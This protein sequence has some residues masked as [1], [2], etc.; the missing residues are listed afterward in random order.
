[1]RYFSERNQ[2]QICIWPPNLVSSDKAGIVKTPGF[3]K[4]LRTEGQ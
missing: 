3:A 2:L 1:M 4:P